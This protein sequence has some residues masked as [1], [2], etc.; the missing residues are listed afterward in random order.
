M[1]V[2]SD[3]PGAFTL[4]FFWP[5]LPILGG[6]HPQDLSDGKV[7]AEVMYGRRH[8]FCLPGETATATDHGYFWRIVSRSDSRLR[9]NI[10]TFPP[11]D[12]HFKS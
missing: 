8:R 2:N 9:R 3:H 10:S 1:D 11:H 12:P 4:Y 7:R 6:S 5:P